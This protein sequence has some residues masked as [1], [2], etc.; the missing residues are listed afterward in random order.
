[1]LLIRSGSGHFGQKMSRMG[2]VSAKKGLIFN[3]CP[4][5]MLTQCHAYLYT[6][7][8]AVRARC[9]YFWQVQICRANPW[10]MILRWHNLSNWLSKLAKQ[11]CE[12]LNWYRL[13]YG[14]LNIKLLK[15]CHRLFYS[16]CARSISTCQK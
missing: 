9:F 11:C 16:Q 3:K 2:Q 13:I 6:N 15:N 4:I 8:W 10:V 14:L 7:G 1:M 12:R 5:K